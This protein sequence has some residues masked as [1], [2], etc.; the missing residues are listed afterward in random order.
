MVRSEIIRLLAL[1]PSLL[2]VCILLAMKC[3]SSSVLG[4]AEPQGDKLRWI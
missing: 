4:I 2:C 3:S 1:D